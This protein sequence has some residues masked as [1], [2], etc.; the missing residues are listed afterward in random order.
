MTTRSIVAERGET[1]S[2]AQMFD[3]REHRGFVFGQL[4]GRFAE[5]LAA[6]G[7]HA[8]HARPKLDHVEVQFENAVLGEVT[9]D[10]DTKSIS[11]S[12]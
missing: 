2:I 9:F 11:C 7:L 4:D 3:R 12:G 6:R 1:R 5:V 8:E 10:H